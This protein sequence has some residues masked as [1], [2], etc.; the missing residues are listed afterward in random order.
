MSLNCKVTP[1]KKGK[2]LD[3][4]LFYECPEW[5]SYQKKKKKKQAFNLKEYL[6]KQAKW[7]KEV[8]I[9]NPGKWDGYSLEEL[10]SK[11][12]AAR[13]RQENRKKEGKAVD[14]QDTSLL[15]ELNFA[16]RAKTGWGKA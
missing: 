13:T 3:T 14:P 11:R 7:G 16:I 6:Y 9:T 2:H 5:P 15:R 12:D 4:Q 8:D 10:K 1:P